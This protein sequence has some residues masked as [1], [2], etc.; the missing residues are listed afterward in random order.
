MS[1]EPTFKS[2]SEYLTQVTS[3]PR[4]NFN[5]VQMNELNEIV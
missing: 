1:S 2:F 3:S 5:L 4:Q